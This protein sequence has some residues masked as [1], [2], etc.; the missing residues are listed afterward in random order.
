MELFPV[1][2]LPLCFPLFLAAC[3]APG[4]LCDATNTFSLQPGE[5]TGPTMRPGANCLRCH[6]ANGEAKDKVFSVG[7]TVFPSADASTCAGVEGVTVRVTDSKG[8]TVTMVTNAVGNF[9]STTPLEQ[10][11]TMEAELGGRVMKMPGTAP[12]GGCALCHSWP[13]PVSA[14]GRIRAP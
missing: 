3:G 9:W 4:P 14:I 13:D 2:L 10:P 11:Y 1:R 12:T 6:V 5:A 8:T 7:G